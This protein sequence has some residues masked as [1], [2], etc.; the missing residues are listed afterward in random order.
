MSATATADPV[1][2]HVEAVLHRAVADITAI[3]CR[4]V[5]RARRAAGGAVDRVATSVT[6]PVGLVRSI[7]ELSISGLLGGLD[8]SATAPA[9]SAPAGQAPP[10]PPAPSSLMTVEAAVGAGLADWSTHL[11]LEGY[12]SLAASQVVDRLDRLARRELEQI[13]EFELA[14]RGRR[15]VLGKI[16]QLLASA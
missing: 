5:G 8:R 1:R 16:D 12:E 2:A 14:H 4:V 10:A 11:P 3:P 6:G 15:T 9:T 13:R 7:V